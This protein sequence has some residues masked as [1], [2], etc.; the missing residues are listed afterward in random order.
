MQSGEEFPIFVDRDDI[1]W[2]QSWQERIVGS[3][4]ETTFLIPVLTPSYLNS[5]WCRRE[6]TIFLRREFDVGRADLVLPIHYVTCEALASPSD[7]LAHILAARQY[8]DWR[9]LRHEPL[10]SPEVG[11]RIA[12][13]G[14]EIVAARKSRTGSKR[15]DQGRRTAKS[16][17]LLPVGTKIAGRFR[18]E[19][20]IGRTTYAIWLQAVDERFNRAVIVH[21]LRTDGLPGEEKERRRFE[22]EAAAFALQTGCDLTDCVHSSRLEDKRPYW[23]LGLD[24]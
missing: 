8:I 18:V 17:P 7:G 12:H 15:T 1:R 4:D 6:I 20:E 21:V 9:D 3:L 23:V 11:R 19:S 5:D 14:K 2:G 10:Q 16:T 13:L 24:R 22:L